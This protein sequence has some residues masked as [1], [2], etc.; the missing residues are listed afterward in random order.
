[1]SC[2]T[3]T[4]LSG[5]WRWAEGQRGP[6][7]SSHA[8]VPALHPSPHPP[9][10]STFPFSCLSPAEK[11]N[12]PEIRAIL[13]EP[14][15]QSPLSET[16]GCLPKPRARQMGETALSGSPS[17]G[18]M[19][20]YGAHE[21]C[22]LSPSREAAVWWPAFPAGLGAASLHQATGT[23][24]CSYLCQPSTRTHGSGTIPGHRAL[25]TA[26]FPR[27]PLEII[28]C[29]A[30]AAPRNRSWLQLP[31]SNQWTKEQG[32]EAQGKSHW[33]QHRTCTTGGSQHYPPFLQEQVTKEP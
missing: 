12:T 32:L 25:P 2:P 10:G 23:S 4:K 27:K 22:W 19:S 24:T 15:E 26:L 18:H 7:G 6:P 3:A 17:Q 16:R 33:H 29:P 31:C 21:C 20:Y 13:A 14:R 1:M 11:T 5:R 9:P 30:P 28:S 8:N